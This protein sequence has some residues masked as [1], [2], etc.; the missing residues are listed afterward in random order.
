METLRQYSNGRWRELENYEKIVVSARARCA[1]LAESEKVLGFD[2]SSRAYSDIM[3]EI[4]AT[5]RWLA[6]ILP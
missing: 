1:Q 2:A 3:D 5:Y 4:Q 6:Q